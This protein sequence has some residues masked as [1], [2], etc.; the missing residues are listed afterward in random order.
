MSGVRSAYRCLPCTR[1]NLRVL[2]SSRF[3][4]LSQSAYMCTA[5]VPELALFFPEESRKLRT[6]V[7]AKQND[8][9]NGLNIPSGLL[10]RPV[11]SCGLIQRILGRGA[12]SCECG[13][14]HTEFSASSGLVRRD[15][16]GGGKGMSGEQPAASPTRGD[17][18][19]L[20]ASTGILFFLSQI[21]L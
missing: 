16:L 14:C 11:T 12:A 2:I 18:L 19:S 17:R 5:F 20:E 6:Y 10:F 8:S 7:N 3:P 1:A 15:H 9:I 13:G 21:R 4:L